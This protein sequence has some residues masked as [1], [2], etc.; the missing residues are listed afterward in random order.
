L[1]L[2]LCKALQKDGFE[3][4]PSAESD[5]WEALLAL[6]RVQDRSV[7]IKPRSVARSQELRARVLSLEAV[8]AL[9]A[10]ERESLRGDDLNP[11]L[12]R[13]YF[14]SGYDDALHADLRIQHFHLGPQG[15]GP[16]GQVG[17]TRE[18]L[19]AVVTDAELLFLDVLDHSAFSSGP[20]V[21]M[22]ANNWPQLFGPPMP[23]IIA[24]EREPGKSLDAERAE[25]RKGGVSTV[26]N[27]DGVLYMPPG[28]AI[29]TSGTPVLVVDRANRVIRHVAD[30]YS[31]LEANADEFAEEVSARLGRPVRELNLHPRL[32]GERLTFVEQ[33]T[34]VVFF[35]VEA[36]L[37]VPRS[38]AMRVFTDPQP[39]L[40]AGK[41]HPARARFSCP[42]SAHGRSTR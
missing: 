13:Q 34:S 35:P 32:A 11:R 24:G 20:F 28:L 38:Y 1:G 12:T 26:I 17:G 42:V 15:A 23:E 33:E 18:L 37:T 29:T 8:A 2:S 27:L 39:P 4:P 40:G 5:A 41:S 22:I 36:R 6:L 21:E 3:V 9:D 19:F 10:I 16:N 25:M 31:W 7:A 30:A 14:R